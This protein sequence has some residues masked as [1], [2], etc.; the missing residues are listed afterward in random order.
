MAAIGGHPYWPSDLEL[1]G[2]VPRQLSALQLV[3]PLIGTSLLVI[4]VVWLVSGH[5]LSTARS[6]R[7]SKAD[8]L[9]MCWWAITGLT[10]LIIEASLLFTPNYL[11]KENPSFFDEIWKEYSK[12]DS[13]YATGDTTTTAVEVIA[14]FLQGPL[15]LLAVYA[16]ASR[17]SYNYILQF[18]VSMSHLYSMLIFYITA[19]LDGMNFCASPFY[20]WTYFVGANSPWVVIPTLIAIR[21][22]KLISQASQSCK[23]NQD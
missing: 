15:S 22:W 19:Y 14:V 21:S 2:F 10:H 8:R 20:F 12:A 23:V 6:G 3:V 5:V 11:T 7:L 13:R 1:P 17:K 4:A 18:S 16:I 9:L